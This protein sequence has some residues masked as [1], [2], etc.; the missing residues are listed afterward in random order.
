MKMQKTKWWAIVLMLLCT[1]F[2]ALGQLFMKKGSAI[3][4][5]KLVSLIFSQNIITTITTIFS[6]PLL[7]GGLLI[8]FGLALYG[9][10][11]VF[12]IASLK[13]GELSLLFP[14]FATNYIWV[15]LLSA[16]ALNEPMNIYKWIGVAGIVLGISL[17]GYGTEKIHKGGK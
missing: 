13:G 15:S 11:A 12:N 5:G 10:A 3:D 2:T 1:V 6:N 17:I 9:I 7:F 16:Y 14:V 4:Y 8:F